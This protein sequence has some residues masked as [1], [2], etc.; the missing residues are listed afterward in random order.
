MNKGPQRRCQVTCLGDNVIHDDRGRVDPRGKPFARDG[1]LARTVPF[2]DGSHE[3]ENFP[4]GVNSGRRALR[5]GAFGRGARMPPGHASLAAM[6]PIV[7]LLA[8]LGVLADHSPAAD[9]ADLPLFD[10]HIHYSRPDWD[11]YSP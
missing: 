8:L 11:V 6:L 4:T 5:P 9:A 10:A 3:L 1:R 7:V 2:A